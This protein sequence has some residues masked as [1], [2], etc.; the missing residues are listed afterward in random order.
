MTKNTA[1]GVFKRDDSCRLFSQ[2]IAWVNGKTVKLFF[3]DGTEDT[4]EKQLI[5]LK[6]LLD[7]KEGWEKKAKQCACEHLREGCWLADEEEREIS[8]DE[9]MSLL[10]LVEISVACDAESFEYTFYDGE[11]YFGHWIVVEGTLQDG[12]VS[13]DIEG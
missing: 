7:D 8:S 5:L 2:E 4:I 12:C 10:S 3:H 9:F 6:S 11:L 13:A 1:I